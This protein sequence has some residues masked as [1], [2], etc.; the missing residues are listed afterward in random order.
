MIA[1]GLVVGFSTYG[2]ALFVW[3]DRKN[4][5]LK[6][7]LGGLNWMFGLGKNKGYIRKSIPVFFEYLKPDYHPWYHDNSNLIAQWRGKLKE[8]KASN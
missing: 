2:T 5:S 8:L 7:T 3:E 6:K 1:L 4:F